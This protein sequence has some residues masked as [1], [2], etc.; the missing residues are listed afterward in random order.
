MTDR[1]TGPPLIHIANGNDVHAAQLPCQPSRIRNDFV[2]EKGSMS[3]R[4][5]E[6]QIERFTR[7]RVAGASEDVSRNNRKHS[8]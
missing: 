3:P 2:D 1:L 4:T 7:R 5:D 6:G 8:G